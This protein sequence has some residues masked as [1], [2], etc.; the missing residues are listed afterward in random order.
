M[1]R[2]RILK[3]SITLPLRVLVLQLRVAR[4]AAELA[5]GVVEEIADHAPWDRSSPGGGLDVDP[6]VPMAVPDPAAPAPG[7]AQARPRDAATSAPR[8]TSTSSRARKPPASTS[9]RARKPRAATTAADIPADEEQPRPRPRRAARKATAARPAR[10]RSSAPSRAEVAK[11]REAEREAEEVAETV[12]SAGPSAHAGA[13]V[14]LAPP[15]EGYDE[16][17]LDEVLARLADADETTLAAV[18]LYESR[19]ESRQAILLATDTP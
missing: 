9:S 6:S 3:L 17:A 7:A 1:N 16:M 18:R 19:G 11:A 4:G 13:E 12:T 5:L 8:P 2:N 15:W 10:K 14:H